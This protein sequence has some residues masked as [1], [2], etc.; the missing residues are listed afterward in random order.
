MNLLAQ[1]DARYPAPVLGA[2]EVGTGAWAGPIYVA[3]AVLPGDREVVRALEQAGLTDS[4]K[5]SRASRERLLSFMEEY[6]TWYTV[7]SATAAEVDRLGV[8]AC[9]DKLYE[10]VLFDALR[11]PCPRSIL[12]DGNPRALPWS[13]SFIPK[14][15]GLSLAIA[16]ASVVAKV[17]RDREMVAVAEAHP[18]YGFEENVGYG[19]PVHAEALE[20]LGPCTIHRTSFRPVR[21]VIDARR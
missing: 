16:A 8:S 15:D 18:G 6:C 9:L 19:V 4:K 13:P 12:I 20:R 7:R 11:G 14:G 21:R 2:D 17:H 10:R 5:L 3:G 1:F